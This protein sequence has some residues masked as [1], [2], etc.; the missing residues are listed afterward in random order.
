MKR[1]L[2]CFCGLLAAGNLGQAQT[3]A[4]WTF[5]G[6]AIAPSTS[7]TYYYGA[8]ENGAGGGGASGF[9]FTLP[10]SVFSGPVGDGSSRSFGANNWAVGDFWLFASISTVGHTGLRLSWDQISSSDGPGVFKLQYST[11]N[12]FTYT[13]FGSDYTVLAN[14]GANTWNSSTYVGASHYTVDLGSVL[15]LNN[16]QTV[17]FRLVADAAISA[18]GG[19][20]T[21]TGM[22][23]VDNFTVI[24]PEPASLA[25]LELCFA[26]LLIWRRRVAG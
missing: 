19:S 3:I 8:P 22:N 6:R 23:Q 20:I 25:L 11:D 4:Q 10:G 9:H 16:A 21:S 2:I 1:F 5:E 15:A 13:T 7:S 18:S 12:G 14:A 17:S 24:V 26:G